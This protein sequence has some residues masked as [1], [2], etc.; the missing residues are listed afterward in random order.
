MF[1]IFSID[2]DVPGIGYGGY[3]QLKEIIDKGIFCF[4]KICF[5]YVRES[6][7]IFANNKMLQGLKIMDGFVQLTGVHYTSWENATQIRSTKRLEPTL[8]DPF[9]YVSEPGKMADWSENKIKKELG[10]FAATAEV[11]LT[12]FVP[13]ELVWIKASRKVIHY[14]IAGI[15]SEEAIWELSIFHRK[16]A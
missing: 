12:L 4:N 2:M 11:K 9:I 8:D 1:R 6:K 15:V 13:V 7:S 14:A 16:A 3:F 10:A 5:I